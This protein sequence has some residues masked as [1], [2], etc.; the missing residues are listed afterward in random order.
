MVYKPSIFE[1]LDILEVEDFSLSFLLLLSLD[2]L[3]QMNGKKE[4]RD[5]E[6][7]DCILDLHQFLFGDFGNDASGDGFLLMLLWVSIFEG[8]E[9]RCRTK[10]S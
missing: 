3:T 2:V 5:G 8:S 9:W 7:Q 6:L 1:E 10:L 4:G